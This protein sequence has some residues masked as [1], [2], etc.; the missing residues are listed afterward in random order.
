MRS[1]RRN[2]KEY[3]IHL[4]FFLALNLF[5]WIQLFKK[6]FAKKR[7]ELSTTRPPLQKIISILFFFFLPNVFI[8]IFLLLILD[9]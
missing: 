8:K 1:K 3:R 4:K 7:P 2:Q 9:N 5:L 6:E